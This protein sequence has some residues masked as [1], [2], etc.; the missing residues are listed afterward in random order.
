[1]RRVFDVPGGGPESH[2]LEVLRDI[3]L[4]IHRG[5]MVSIVGPSGVGKSTLLQILGTLD[6]PSD[7]TLTYGAQDV[8]SLAEERLAAF[9]NEQVGFIF[10]FHHL[11]SEFSALENV[12]L[13]ALIG[14]RTRREAAGAAESLLCEVGLK[15]RLIH[16]PGELSGGEQQR[17]AIARALVMGPSVVFADEPTGN[18][19]GGTSDEIHQLLMSLNERTGTAFV[20]VTH[21]MRFARLMKRHL[22]LSRGAIREVS[23]DES[24]D[25]FSGAAGGEPS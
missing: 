19:D 8:F 10:Q 11:L 22:L 12:M 1:M 7:G 17:V 25:V 13:P 15:D 23:G 14:G 18:L 21:N 20:V 4:D 2:T 24:P 16:K 6:R 5:E 3:D 9:R